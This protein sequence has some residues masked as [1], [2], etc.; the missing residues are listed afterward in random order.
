MALQTVSE[1]PGLRRPDTVLVRRKKTVHSTVPV[2]GGIPPARW[3]YA[4]GRPLGWMSRTINQLATCVGCLTITWCHA[5]HVVAFESSHVSIPGKTVTEFIFF[6]QFR[7]P[8]ISCSC[9]L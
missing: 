5:V 3:I 9:L 8:K 2:P 1:S 4:G 6:S 7:G